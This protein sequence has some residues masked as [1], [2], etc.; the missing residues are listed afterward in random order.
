MKR[1]SLWF[2]VLV[3]IANLVAILLDERIGQ[4][5]TKPLILCSL[6][7][8]YWVSTSRRSTVFTLALVFSL[9][10]D[11]SL[12]FAHAGEHYFI[13]GLVSFLIAH[14]FYIVT[15]RQMR[16][17][18]IGQ[19]LLGTQRVRFSFP[20]MLVGA[21]LVLTLFPLLGSLQIPVVIYASV[22]VLMVLQAI[23]RF[24]FTTPG[25]FR[26]VVTGAL[27]FFVS[28]IILA[29]NKFL[30]PIE[31]GELMIMVT[32]ILAQYFIVQGVRAHPYGKA[33]AE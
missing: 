7:F 33:T 4:L 27:F 19:E 31:G 18:G 6:L 20:V 32:Y 2:F 24:G 17:K 10:G 23:Y 14:V 11:V 13:G 5:I 8:Y 21:G 15:Y 16:I 3:S 25:S 30:H 26:M 1:F 29:L 22:L 12:L 28:D 9:L